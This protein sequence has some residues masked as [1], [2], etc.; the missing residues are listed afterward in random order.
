VTSILLRVGAFLRNLAGWRRLVTAF[1][2][3]ALSALGFA[4]FNAIALLLLAF[5]VLVVLLDG[6]SAERKRIANAAAIG[7]TFGFGQFLVGMHWIFYPFL[8]D[9]VQHA[10][11]IPFVAVLF[12]GGLALFCALA[13]MASMPVWSGGP[14]RIFTL[15]TTYAAAEWLRGHVLTGLPWNLPAYGWGASLDV[16]QSTA[17]V[18]V[19][20]LTLLTVLFGASFSELL[21]APRRWLLPALT[22]SAFVVIWLGGAARLYATPTAYVADVHLRIVQPNIPQDEKYRRALVQRNW[23]R[24]VDLSTKPTGTSPSVIIWPEA[25]PPI[26]LQRSQGAREQIALLT[27]PNRVLITGNQRMAAGTDD[28]RNFYNSLYIF[29]FQGRLL[30]TYDKFHLVPF[31][32]YMPLRDIMRALGITKLVGFPGS[33]SSGDGPHTYPVPGAP[34]VGPLICYE[35]LFPGAVI[36]ERRPGWLVNV[37]DDSWFGPWAG[38]RQHLLAARVRAI[39]EGLPVVRSANTGVSAVIDPLGRTIV[40]LGLDQTGEIDSPLPRALAMPAYARYGDAGFLVLLMVSAG[41]SWWLA[42]K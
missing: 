14:A 38:P 34:D 13:C 26:L 30:S 11:Q 28:E 32:E 17:L 2:A 4:P 15:A 40:T 8:V 19:Y 16:L 1:A 10:W 27:G 22:T 9:P 31:G 35:I 18:G 39:E 6:A 3:G 7:W 5:A 41:L 20:G 25:A 33:F 24:L 29:G 42:R 21:G 12:P 36:G 37:T 23:D